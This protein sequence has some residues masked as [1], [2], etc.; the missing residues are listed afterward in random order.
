MIRLRKKYKYFVTVQ[1]VHTSSEGRDMFQSW[2]RLP[3]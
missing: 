1:G 2:M 3:L